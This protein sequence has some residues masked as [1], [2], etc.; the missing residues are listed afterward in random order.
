MTELFLVRHGQAGAT[1]E[2]YDELSALGRQQ[3]L[4]L[5][6]WLIAHG[7]S[8]S[9]MVVGRMRRQRETLDAIRE[10]YVAAGQEPPVAQTL[11][12][13]DEYRFADMLRAFAVAEPEHPE[14]LSVRSSPTDRRLWIGLLRTTLSAWSRGALNG[15]PESYAEFQ[16]RARA[17]LV[18]IEQRLAVGPVLA[19][20]SGG[21][22]SQ[23]AQQVLGFD[24][25][26]AIDVNL[27]LLNT[28][29]CE[30]RLTRSGLKLAS[31]NGLPHL[32]AAADRPL[33]TLV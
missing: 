11:P 22:M 8:F 23:L 21:V 5:G 18:D 31:L 29:V 12:G 17:A 20:S 2:N 4:R 9:A 19:V 26:T 32:S 15:V 13:L 16:A 3:A 28:S 24:D 14:L 1:P 27:Q 6:E 7:R 25:A 33:V 30:Y 10:V